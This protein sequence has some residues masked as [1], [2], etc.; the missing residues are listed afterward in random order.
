MN[1][2]LSMALSAVPILILLNAFFVSAEYAV[3]SIRPAQV[4][5]LRNSGRL[6]TANAIERLKADP[7][8]A[9][10]AIQ[11]CITM[12]NLM[13]GW[14]GEPAMS[15]LLVKAMGP[16]ASY[17][18]PAVFQTISV[19]LSF[20]IVTLLT[21]VLSELLPKALTLRYGMVAATLTAQPILWVQWLVRP[22]VWLMTHMANAVT[23]ALGLG[24][25]DELDDEP[26][27]VDELRLLAQRAGESGAL[28]SQEQKLVLNSLALNQRKARDV[29]VH[30]SSVAHLD[31]QKSMDDNRRVMNAH[32]FSRL[33]LVNGGFDRI[34]G[35]VPTREFLSAYHAEGDS[36][37]LQLIAR[38]PIFVP[39]QATVDK[40]L[41]EFSAQRT[42]MMFVVN[43]YGGVEG[44][45]TLTDVVDTLLHQTIDQE[46]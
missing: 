3:V 38:K 15:A 16:L 31:L 28:G 17:L 39:E 33:P 45:V 36:S 4:A 27:T 40:L 42:Q 37:V 24:R 46:T 13:L 41:N 7:A 21:V 8:S 26:V 35:I 22:L 18:H 19:G 1:M 12:T 32:L 23:T 20:I 25:V 6:R 43:E 30:R 10:G 9:I 29:M 14:I 44:I 2:S 5:A 34:V 11:V